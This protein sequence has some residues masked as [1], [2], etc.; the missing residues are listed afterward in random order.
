MARRPASEMR[1]AI[2][3]WGLKR[4]DEGRKCC[5]IVVIDSLNDLQWDTHIRIRRVT[6]GALSICE[7]IRVPS[8]HKHD[9][10]TTEDV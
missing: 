5:S 7:K 4:A 1:I 3:S 6:L 10:D 2:F 8:K 9:G